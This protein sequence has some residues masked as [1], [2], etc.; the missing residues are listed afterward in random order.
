[1]VNSLKTN[2]FKVDLVQPSDFV[3]FQRSCRLY[4]KSSFSYFLSNILIKSFGCRFLRF[5]MEYFTFL[6]VS[7]FHIRSCRKWICLPIP[8]I[9]RLP[10]RDFLTCVYL[11]VCLTD[12]TDR[13]TLRPKLLLKWLVDFEFVKTRYS[14]IGHTVLL[15]DIVNIVL[16]RKNILTYWKNGLETIFETL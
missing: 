15:A 1:M 8:L 14:V 11:Y 3:R 6:M 16:Y 7:G 4:S 5:S 10:L 12:Y 13:N 2:E 9:Q